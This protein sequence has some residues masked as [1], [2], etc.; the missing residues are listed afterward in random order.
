MPLLRK[1]H[2]SLK[3]SRE[4]WDKVKQNIGS[5]SDDLVLNDVIDAYLERDKI[6]EKLQAAS[7]TIADLEDKCERLEKEKTGLSNHNREMQKTEKNLK[8]KSRLLECKYREAKE[9]LKI[10]EL[11]ESRKEPEIKEKIVYVKDTET[12][13]AL[14]DKRDKLQ[15]KLWGRENQLKQAKKELDGLKSTLESK[16]MNEHAILV[17]YNDDEKKFDI[18]K[19]SWSEF[20]RYMRDKRMFCRSKEIPPGTPY[21]VVQVWTEMI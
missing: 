10:K 18:E 11:V 19:V 8:K 4:L 20:N 1:K 15:K 16:Q 7:K 9:K 21:C 6:T 5:M 12:L 14:R 13:N 2:I 17:K 3:V